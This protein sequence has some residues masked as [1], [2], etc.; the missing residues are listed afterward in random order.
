MSFLD[1]EEEAARLVDNLQ[2]LKHE[3]DAQTEINNRLTQASE[4]MTELSKETRNVLRETRAL[5]E[6]LGTQAVSEL[7]DALAGVRTRIASLEITLTQHLGKHEQ[8]LKKIETNI[9]ASHAKLQDEITALKAS[10]EK[11]KTWLFG[12]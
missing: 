1:L 10:A 11:K 6:K 12:K 4:T 3:A 2:Q 9:L 7:S 5:S 8:H